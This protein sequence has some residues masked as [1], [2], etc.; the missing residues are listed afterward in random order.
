MKMLIRLLAFALLPFT[1]KATLPAGAVINIMS[2]GS[3]NNGGGF[4]AAR[5]GTDYSLQNGHQLTGTDGSASGTTT[6]TS[7]TGGFTTAMEGNYLHITASTGLTVGWY[8]IVTRTDTNNVVLDRTPGTGTASTYFVGGALSLGNTLDDDLFEMGV[9]GNIY[10]IKGAAT[11]TLGENVT[12]SASGGA[13]SPIMIRGYTTTFTDWTST[14]GTNRPTIAAGANTCTFGTNWELYNIIGTTTSSTGIVIGSSGK[15]DN[16]K[17]TNSSTTAARPAL[18][19]SS[20]A[21]AINCESVSYRGVG[22][23][24]N[25]SGG[26]QV[27][28]CYVHDSDIGV[29]YNTTGSLVV[30]GSIIAS[31][32][33]NGIDTAGAAVGS[34]LILGNTLFGSTNTTGTGVSFATGTTNARLI[35]NIITG[36]VTGVAHA[37]SQTIGFDNWNDYHNNDTDVTN[38]TKGAN[39]TAVA[40]SFTSVGQV[41]G[42]TATTSGSVL[43]QA[44][45]DFTASGVV[46]G[47]DFIYLVSGTGITAG[48]Y[49]I[50]IV[51]TTTLTLDIAPG[52][53]ATADK[54]FQITIGRNFAVGTAM[55][56]LGFPGAFQGGYTTGY[57]DQGA[58]QRQEAAAGGQKS[59]SF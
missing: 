4:N 29:R 20:N 8:E 25:G 1:A 43:T 47:R 52:T 49:G 39:D 13:S 33:T 38:W 37:D 11:Y 36:F 7:V 53:N 58:A 26:A 31:C 35:N 17:F 3:N 48:V 24:G 14:T 6:F 41:T 18:S 2:T 19:L 28:G 5:G 32:V 45:A 15:G 12:I 46:A 27:Y 16:C 42:A 54:V 10:Y 34:T 50:T 21:T 56:A 59:Y 22:I 23:L 51:G 40:P 30:L 44:G 57:L 9:A 55:K